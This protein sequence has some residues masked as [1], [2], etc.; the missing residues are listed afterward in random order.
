MKYYSRND[1]LFLAVICLIH[2]VYFVLA[3]HYKHIFNGDSFEYIYEAINIRDYNFFYSGNPGLPI[4]EEY[5]TLRTPGYPLFLL[6]VYSFAV[7]NWMVLFLQNLVSI[8][9]IMLARYTLKIVGYSVKLDWLF[10]MFIILFPSQFIY[11]NTIAPD[12]LLQTFCLVYFSHAIAFLKTGRVKNMLAMAV[13]I[14]VGL[15]IKP[16]LYPLA[17]IHCIAFVIYTFV[18]HGRLTKSAVTAFI[19]ILIVCFYCFWNQQRTGK[20][21]FTSIQSFN[22]I[23][24]YNNY[25]KSTKG[26]TEARNFLTVERSAIAALPSLKE[27]YDYAQSRGIDLLKRENV[28]YLL[29]H[30]KRSAEF[31]VETGKGEMELFLG[32][33]TLGKLYADDTKGLRTILRESGFSGLTKHLLHHPAGFFAILILGVNILR[34]AGFVLFFVFDEQRAIIKWFIGLYVVYFAAITGPISNAHY[35]LPISLIL[36]GCASIG[37]SR[38]LTVKNNRPIITQ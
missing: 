23:Y 36:M 28:S 17:I 14:T 9:N 7:N 6:L 16:V 29:F 5:K 13:A 35:V 21:H 20:F 31:F 4:E 12:I 38:L 18:Q 25:L 32:N 26:T 30:L 37:L 2:T 33:N 34:L 8:F 3:W 1:L 10:L 19:P 24:Y 27:R 11:A 15:F 22:A